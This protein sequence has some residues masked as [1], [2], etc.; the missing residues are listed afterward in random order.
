MNDH[1]RHIFDLYEHPELGLRAVR[2][3]FS[4]EAFLFPAFWAV[5]RGMGWTALTLIVLTTA[6]FD[7]ARFSAGLGFGPLEQ[8]IFMV[9]GIMLLGI[10]PGVDGYL[11]IGQ[12]LTKE[13]YGLRGAVAAASRRKA[14][15]AMA[16]QAFTDKPIAVAA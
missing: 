14:L 3:G 7:L 6:V 11:W 16:G 8:F 5:R 1:A 13:G 9:A 4:W 15:E 12:V 10:K 2:R